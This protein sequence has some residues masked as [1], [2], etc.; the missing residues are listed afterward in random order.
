MSAC[1][2]TEE[3]G[4]ARPMPFPDAWRERIV[5]YQAATGGA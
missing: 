1:H 2:V 4:R 5:A 3:G